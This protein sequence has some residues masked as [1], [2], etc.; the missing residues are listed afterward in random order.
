MKIVEK[1]WG[2][3]EWIVNNELYC[4][5]KLYLKKGYQCSM[6][7]HMIK[8]ETFII[9]YGTVQ[10]EA[11]VPILMNKGEQVRIKPNTYH[12][13]LGITDAVIIEISTQHIDED[14]YRLTK[15]GE[16]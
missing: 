15:S 10:M 8:D 1:V 12:R 9:Q 2:R 7:K 11:R 3:E 13:F 5:K 14:S 4:Y 6:H 16:Y